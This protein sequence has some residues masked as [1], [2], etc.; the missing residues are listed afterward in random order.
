M[1]QTFSL[2]GGRAF[3]GTEPVEE[4]P[5]LEAMLVVD[6]VDHTACTSTCPSP[7]ASACVSAR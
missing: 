7:I 6:V 5:V 2:S 3:V 4:V 1:L